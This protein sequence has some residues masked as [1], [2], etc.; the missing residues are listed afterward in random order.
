MAEAI[1]PQEELP[2]GS[3][4]HRASGWWGVWC[5]IA[6]EGSLFAYLLFSYLY[7]TVL[8]TS[9]W[10]PNG[11]PDLT[12]AAPNTAILLAS[13]F[14]LWWGERGIKQGRRLRLIVCIGIA[15]ALGTI[16][17]LLQL[18]E[19]SNKPFTLWTS[20]YS[21][22]FFTITGF[23]LMHVIVGLITLA[24]LFVW[25]LL[26]YFGRDRHAPLSIGALYWHFVDAVWLFVFTILYLTPLLG[27]VHA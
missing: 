24:V 14:V 5:L 8:T 19:W 13:S 27:L 23:H 10:P 16:F 12:I 2:V 18:K 21:S 6:T 20:T 15:F 4:R 9:T 17:A 22:L 11:P 26:G 25:A 7:V 3:Y 1:A